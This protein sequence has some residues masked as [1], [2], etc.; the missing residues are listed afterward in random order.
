MQQKT[1]KFTTRPDNLQRL[2][3]L[4]ENV[5]TIKTCAVCESGHSQQLHFYDRH[6]GGQGV[7]NMAANARTASHLWV[8]STPVGHWAALWRQ[9]ALQLRGLSDQ[10]VQLTSDHRP[11]TVCVLRL[12]LEGL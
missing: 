4:Y 3:P 8:C 5:N 12:Q 1:H 9:F 7:E 10:L 6:V 2:T 11:V